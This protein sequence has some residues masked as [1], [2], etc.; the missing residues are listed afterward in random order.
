MLFMV[1][2]EIKLLENQQLLLFS[3]YD[4]KMN[5]ENSHCSLE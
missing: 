2:S 1:T 4:F 3:E 5:L